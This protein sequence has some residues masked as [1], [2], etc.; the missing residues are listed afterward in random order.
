MA[1]GSGQE[2]RLFRLCKKLGAEALQVQNYAGVIFTPGD[3]QVEVLPKLGK[4][5]QAN[6]TATP[7]PAAR[8]EEARHALLIML[9]A[10][11]EF[12]IFKQRTPTSASKKMRCWRCSLA[13]FLIR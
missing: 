1:L 6:D 11:R 2:N 4:P 3:A 9:R 12:P 13:N 8:C 10:L 5:V 7:C